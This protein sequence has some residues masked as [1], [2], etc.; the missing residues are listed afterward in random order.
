M[1]YLQLD[2]MSIEKKRELLF[3]WIRNMDEDALEQLIIEFIYG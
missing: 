3:D 2:N 1:E